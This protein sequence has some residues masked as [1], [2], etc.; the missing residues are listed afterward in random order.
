M[1]DIF[2]G[3]VSSTHGIKG[4]IKIRSDFELKDEVFKVGNSIIIGG[5]SYK[6]TSYRV[7]KGYDMVT[8]EGLNDIN[9]V[10]IFKGKDVY[11]KREQLNLED[12]E[13][14]LDDLIG[15]DIYLDEKNLGT[16]KDYVTGLNPLLEIIGEK[17]FYIPLNGN[18]IINVD[19]NDKK[20]FVSD[21]VKGLL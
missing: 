18:Y 20:I 19:L 3:K 15:M 9:Q 21:E 17:K 1:K 12:D 4:E 10:L 5:Q 7:H 14:V 16:V 13:Y 2:I 11:V 6:I 8:L